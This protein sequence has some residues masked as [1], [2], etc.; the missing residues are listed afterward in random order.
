MMSSLANDVIYCC[1]PIL[2]N[3]FHFQFEEKIFKFEYKVIMQDKSCAW[4]PIAE[5]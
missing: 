2:R 1:F 5:K 3:V 4:I